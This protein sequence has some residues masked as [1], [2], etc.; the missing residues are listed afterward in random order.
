ME[1]NLEIRQFVV[2]EDGYYAWRNKYNDLAGREWIFGM[3]YKGDKICG[4]Y[5]GC[6]PVK[7]VVKEKL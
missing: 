4:A 7:F 2:E 1:G 3:C 5:E 6:G